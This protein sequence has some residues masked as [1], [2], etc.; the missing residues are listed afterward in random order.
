[1]RAVAT[2]LADG[3]PGTGGKPRIGVKLKGDWHKGHVEQLKAGVLGVRFSRGNKFWTAPATVDTCH[4][5]R[6]TFGEALEIKPALVAWYREHRLEADAQAARANL[7]DE[8]LVRLPQAAPALF[9]TLRPDQRVGVAWFAAG[10]RGGGVLADQ[11]GLGKTLEAIGG[12]LEA[13]VRGPVLVVAPRLSVRRVWGREL[14]KWAPDEHVYVCRG[15]RATRERQL[16]R[17]LQD[18]SERKWLVVVAQM[19]QVVRSEVKPGAPKVTRKRRGRVEDYKYPDLFYG[20]PWAAVIADESHRLLGSLTVAKANLMGEGLATLPL[21]P[22]P[23]LRAVSGTPFGKGGRVQGMFG[24]LHWMWQDEYTSFWRWAES[25]FEIEEQQVYIK[26]G[27]GQRRSTRKVGNLRKG[28]TEE[29]FYAS[30]GPRILRRTKEEVLKHLPP[31]QYIDVP[32]EMEGAQLRQ[33]KQLTDEAEV[34]VPGGVVMANGVLAERTRARQLANGAVRVGDSGKVEFL[35]GES[36][37]VAQLM[38]ILDEHGNLD[39]SGGKV[40]IASQFNEF[41]YGAVIPALEQAG[42]E[43]H[44]LTGKTSDKARDQQM[45]A[46]Q[47]EGGPQVFVMN[48]KAGGISI[49]LDAADDL[50]QLDRLDNP[51][52]EEQLHDRVHRAS[53]VHQVTIYRYESE[54]TID[55]N[56]AEMVGEKEEEQF[57]VLD[58]RRGLE[59]LRKVIRYQPPST[60]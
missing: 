10:Y 59:F 35:T 47:A 55:T 43:F 51:E 34:V 42:V 27:R 5:L 60:D 1:M 46:F 25:L 32:C 24:T 54:G 50:H 23:M 21:A 49:T 33:Y 3:V 57:A 58:G 11:P 48:S 7:S 28:K 41:L 40:I 53:R 52:D 13:D 14:A 31:K 12:V 56:V 44:L 19:L 29:D 6:S 16:H 20:E 38:E 45:D 30:L 15:S 37:K 17:F 2:Y 26:G 18:D 39:G 36:C 22:D 9:A 4:A 8:Q